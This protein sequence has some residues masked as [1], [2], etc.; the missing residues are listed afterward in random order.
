MNEGMRT[1][2][3]APRETDHARRKRRDAERAELITV[4]GNVCWICGRPPKTRAL[5]VDHDHRTGRNR[6]LLCW[7]CNRGLPTSADAVWLRAAAD[8]LDAAA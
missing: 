2:H 8:Y 1:A 6:G 4:R 5:H 7:S 3:R